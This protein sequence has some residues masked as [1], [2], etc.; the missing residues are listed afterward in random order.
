MAFQ[1]W[2]DGLLHVSVAQL[3]EAPVLRTGKCGFESHRWHFRINLE[4]NKKGMIL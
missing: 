1:G 4:I 3:A 2:N